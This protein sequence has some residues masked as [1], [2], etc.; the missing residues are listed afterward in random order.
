MRKKS[1]AILLAAAMLLAI[2][3]PAMAAGATSVITAPSG[4]VKAGE[5][6]DVT[7]ELKNNPGFAKI[8]FT[9]AYDRN[10]VTCNRIVVGELLSGTV[11][12]AN[13]KAGDGAA[14]V[15]ATLEDIVDD[16][17][18]F[19]IKFTAKQDLT[20]SE[21]E[22]VKY[23]VGPQVGD[24]YTASLKWEGNYGSQTDPVTPDPVD[25]KPPVNPTPTPDP[26]PTPTPDPVTPPSDGGTTTELPNFNDI[27]GHWAE[28]SIRR[29][30]QLGLFKGYP[31]GN[32][33]PEDNVTRA[34][35]VTV[36]YRMAGS[37]AVTTEAPFTDTQT[38]SAEFRTAINWAYA[39]GSVN[40]KTAT[41]FDPQG[42]I[43]RQEALKILF[44]YAGGQSGM[45]LLVTPIYDSSFADS[46]QI[47]AWA[48]PAMY[49]GVYHEIISGQ[50]T[51][52]LRPTT[53]A[54]RAELADILVNYLDKF[55]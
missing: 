2:S 3:I 35:F 44:Y 20:G 4:A 10:A 7:G 49:W 38:Q 12:A 16:G 18:L 19:T 15:A 31:G 27:S 46:D 25:P 47:G 41:T 32:F 9:M 26:T 17:L 55:Q 36:L 45:E 50:G 14:I 48:K 42:S 1:I 13:P 43:T 11:Y 22:A 30:A 34:Q 53:P 39:T 52:R 6:F 54:T 21:L 28:Q 51:D 5:S 40:G 23:L 33:G 29:S 24:Y 8:E 37:P